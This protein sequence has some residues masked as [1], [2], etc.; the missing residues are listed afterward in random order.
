[1]TIEV[2][3]HA[4][5]GKTI[6]RRQIEQEVARMLV[7]AQSLAVDGIMDLHYT[8]IQKPDDAFTRARH[9]VRVRIHRSD[10]V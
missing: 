8:P 7:H 3:F 9:G 1:M 5:Q 6:S 4:N 10:E 2:K